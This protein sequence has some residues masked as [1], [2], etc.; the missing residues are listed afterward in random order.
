MLAILAVTGSIATVRT[1]NT[2]VQFR[3]LESHDVPSGPGNESSPLLCPPI[4]CSALPVSSRVSGVPDWP[5]GPMILSSYVWNEEEPS[6]FVWAESGVHSQPSVLSS[7]NA[8]LAWARSL[9]LSTRPW[10]GWAQLQ[11]ISEGKCRHKEGSCDHGILNY[12]SKR[13]QRPKK[14]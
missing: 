1:L 13:T 4:K 10:L 8:S 9:P 7:R 6:W 14:G 5:S 12:S 11:L 3:Y 2:A